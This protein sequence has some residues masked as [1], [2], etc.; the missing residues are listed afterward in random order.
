MEEYS[1]NPSVYVIK[2]SLFNRRTFNLTTLRRFLEAHGYTDEVMQKIF[3]EMCNLTPVAQIADLVNF[4][5]IN[6]ALKVSRISS[7][8]DSDEFIQ[9]IYPAKL[10]TSLGLSAIRQITLC[11]Q[12]PYNMAGLL[13][14]QTNKA[15]PSEVEKL[16]QLPDDTIYYPDLLRAVYIAAFTNTSIKGIGYLLNVGPK[17]I[18][19]ALQILKDQFPNSGSTR[20]LY[21]LGKRRLDIDDSVKSFRERNRELITSTVGDAQ[22]RR[23][24]KDGDFEMAFSYYDGIYKPVLESLL[25]K[26]GEEGRR[27]CWAYFFLHYGLTRSD[28]THSHT[29]VYSTTEFDKD[30]SVIKRELYEHFSK[31]RNYTVLREYRRNKNIFLPKSFVGEWVESKLAKLRIKAQILFDILV[32]LGQP[33]SATQ[34]VSMISKG[35][36]QFATKDFVVEEGQIRYNLGTDSEKIWRM[37]GNQSFR[38]EWRQIVSHF[39]WP[40]NIT[41]SEFIKY[42]DVE[43]FIEA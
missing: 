39:G 12:Y 11:G 17:R 37:Y 10:L 29:G 26:Y 33:Y 9:A 3:F 32:E 14:V 40:E 20:H 24:L 2:D 5:H 4:S 35:E 38:Y 19:L 25:Q 1:N 30:I 15:I 43:F 21:L 31:E 6:V 7:I 36:I 42:N 18:S 28:I 34:L 16:P 13:G 27:M 23:A 41:M 8:L 22:M